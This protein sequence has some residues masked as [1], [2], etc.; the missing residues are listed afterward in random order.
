MSLKIIGVG[1]AHDNPIGFRHNQW[2]LG[3]TQNVDS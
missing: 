1:G 2:L 3:R